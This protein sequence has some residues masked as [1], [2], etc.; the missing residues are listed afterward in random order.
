MEVVNY[1]M[2][3]AEERIVAQN[4]LRNRT[5]YLAMSLDSTSEDVRLQV[6]DTFCL[7]E[8]STFIKTT[9]DGYNEEGLPSV[10]VG[11]NVNMRKPDIW[12]RVSVPAN[13]DFSFVGSLSMRYMDGLVKV[14]IGCAEDV[15]SEKIEEL[16]HRL[17]WNMERIGK[18][19]EFHAQ[20]AMNEYFSNEVTHKYLMDNDLE[21]YEDGII[22]EEEI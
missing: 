11:V 13:I 19:A 21:V 18:H 20:A 10:L 5:E 1:S 9:F 2:L 22:A 17:E 7:P 14:E 12:L 15:P 16:T 3:G 6:E 8:S 4:N